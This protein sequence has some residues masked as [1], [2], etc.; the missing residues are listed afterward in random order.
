MPVEIDEGGARE[1]GRLDSD[2]EQTQVMTDGHEAHGREEE[3]QA[4]GEHPLGRV[5]EQCPF[6]E[7]GARARSLA[8]AG[9]TQ[10]GCHLSRSN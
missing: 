1:R 3:Q 9:T 2:P 8:S 4:G 5:G 7:V 10:G 6:L